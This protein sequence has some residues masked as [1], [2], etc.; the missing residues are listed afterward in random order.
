MATTDTEVAEEYGEVL[1]TRLPL[2]MELRL[3]E[4]AAKHER[5]VAAELRLAVR[6]YLARVNRE[7]QT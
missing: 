3:R 4:N 5:S 2:S 7:E 6:Q 1:S